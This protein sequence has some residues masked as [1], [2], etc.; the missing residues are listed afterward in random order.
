MAVGFHVPDH[1]SEAPEFG[2]TTGH[3]VHTSLEVVG[4]IRPVQ[5]GDGVFRAVVVVE[6]A[7]VLDFDEFHI[8]V[9]VSV[10]SRIRRG[11]CRILPTPI[12]SQIG[13]IC[14][15]IICNYFEADFIGFL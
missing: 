11:D 7:T 15:Y 3:P 14:Q 12:A 13:G 1:V 9:C 5:V 10:T 6:S 4:F 8:F 2:V